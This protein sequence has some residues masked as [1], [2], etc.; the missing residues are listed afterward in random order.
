MEE[1]TLNWES[2][3]LAEARL[4]KQTVGRT[5]MES[6]AQGTFDEEMIGAIAWVT[7]RRTDPDATL[8]SVLERIS[9]A[10]LGSLLEGMQRSPKGP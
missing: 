2:I 4:I 9:Y 1:L 7:I 10:Q 3:T 8:D 5:P 6:A